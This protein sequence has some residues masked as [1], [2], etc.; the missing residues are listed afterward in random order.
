MYPAHQS[1]HVKF[2][3]SNLLYESHVCFTRS[4]FMT[5]SAVIGALGGVWKVYIVS[6]AEFTQGDSGEGIWFLDFK[7]NNEGRCSCY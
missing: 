3:T 6:I 2:V 5:G 7:L 4:G 1:Q